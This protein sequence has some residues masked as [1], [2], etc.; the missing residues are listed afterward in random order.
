MHFVA[1]EYG[2]KYKFYWFLDKLLQGASQKAHRYAKLKKMFRFLSVTIVT[3]VYL[4][5]L[6]IL[7]ANV[8]AFAFFVNV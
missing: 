8:N 6:S 7:I 2:S 4:K 1:P 5:L 3:P